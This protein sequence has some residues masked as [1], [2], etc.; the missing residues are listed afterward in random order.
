MSRF[1]RLWRTTTFR[2][3]ALFLAIFVVLAVAIL[4]Y[5]AYQSVY[6]IQEQQVASIER[7]LNQ[8]ESEYARGGTRGLVLAIQRF[9]Q[10]PG[11]GIYYVADPN[12]VGVAGNVL[13]VPA[14]V[15][16]QPGAHTFNYE[17]PFA[18]EG[19]A[20]LTGVAMVR[21]F[22]LPSGFYLVVGRDIVERRS[23]AVIVLQA[24]FWGV[25]LIVVFGVVAGAVSAQRVLRRIDSI[26]ATSEAI[27]AG[28][29]GERVP[30]TKR[31]DEFDRL[32]TSLNAM[33]DR[34]QQLV[35]G[36]KAV[37]DNIA[38]D[39]K[40]PLTRMRNRIEAALREGK[41]GVAAREAL[42]STIEESDQLIKTFNALL[43]IARVEAGTAAGDF[44]Q[45][46]LSEVV[47]DLAELYAPVAEDAGLALKVEAGTG[48]SARA[49]RELVGQALVN[50]VEN[51]LKY[52]KPA[53]GGGEVSIQVSENGGEVVLE[54][55]DRGPGIPE[56]DRERVLER[57]VRLDESRAE[58]GFGLGLSLV[59]AVA[60]LHK[61]RV[62]I[63]D[64]SPG[65]RIRLILPKA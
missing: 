11:P 59:S 3:T 13:D 64:N 27:M 34:I 16:Q 18:E 44:E 26:T 29:M 4:G 42:E 61:G 32:A 47:K 57:F 1:W 51:A 31:G 37:S 5:I 56:A 50:L 23:F 6:L 38:H 39:L 41:D 21:S 62:E 60:H 52:G 40:T 35:A 30:V 65:A 8:L 53:G 28:A 63:G 2:L 14:Q 15:L 49:N 12:G 22:I 7:E 45:V 36:M 54:V 17:R 43:L 48:V 33:L 46:D 55:A 9:A 58:P 10:G 20:N 25:V 19:D 24:F